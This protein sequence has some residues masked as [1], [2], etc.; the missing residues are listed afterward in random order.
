MWIWAI[1]R[2]GGATLPTSRFSQ[3]SRS[4]RDLSDPA[5]LAYYE[6]VKT[7]RDRLLLQGASITTLDDWATPDFP[8]KG[9]DIIAAGV[10]AGPDVSRIL[11]RT[12]AAWVA[13]GFPQEDEAREILAKL[14]ADR[15]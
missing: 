2:P 11:E 4:P 3:A 7:A 12:R 14:L 13:R 5:A 10:P 9:R 15:A 6:G 1:C 8:L